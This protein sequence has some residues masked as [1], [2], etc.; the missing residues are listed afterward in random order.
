MVGSIDYIYDLLD[1]YS[2]KNPFYEDIT[3]DIA[4]KLEEYQKKT[5]VLGI[6]TIVLYTLAYMVSLYISF[7][8]V[9][10][11]LRDNYNP[12]TDGSSWT[13]FALNDAAFV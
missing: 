13:A 11:Y 3:T 6:A 5:F 8:D 12:S 10:I 1:L 7:M 4:T 2:P 9:E